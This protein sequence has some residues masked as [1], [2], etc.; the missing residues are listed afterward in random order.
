M[1]PAAAC[2]SNACSDCIIP[3]IQILS[4]ACYTAVMSNQPVQHAMATAP[5]MLLAPPHLHGQRLAVLRKFLEDGVSI[6]DALLVL[7]CLRHMSKRAG[8]GRRGWRGRQA[9]P[10]PP[11]PSSSQPTLSRALQRHPHWRRAGGIIVHCIACLRQ[12]KLRQAPAKGHWS[13][14]ACYSP[15]LVLFGQLP[16]QGRLLAWQLPI[17]SRRGAR[18]GARHHRSVRR[19]CAW[20]FR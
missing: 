16:E 3:C 4:T 9:P 11:P 7:L 20:A 18:L 19:R 14:L 12:P 17:G 1:E 13:P 2:S 8:Q 15:H 6:L 5:A 10:P